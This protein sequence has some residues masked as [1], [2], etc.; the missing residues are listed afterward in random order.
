[1]RKGVVR[2]VT[3]RLCFGVRL[4]GVPSP[5]NNRREC[6]VVRSLVALFEAVGFVIGHW[7]CWILLWLL[8]GVVASC[9]SRPSCRFRSSN[10]D[11][12]VLLMS[13]FC[14]STR[15]RFSFRA[16]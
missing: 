1:M 12:F 15:V 14:V 2:A 5:M 3:K 4:E 11:I 13:G 7:C 9:F 6:D 16:P 8:L 10:P